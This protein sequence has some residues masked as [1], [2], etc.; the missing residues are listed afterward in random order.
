MTCCGRCKICRPEW[1]ELEADRDRLAARVAE[2]ERERD[3]LH[4]D[5]LAGP[6]QAQVDRFIAERDVALAE[7]ERAK[8]Q[9]EIDRRKI[10]E[11]RLAAE[12]SWDLV[13]D[14][15]GDVTDAT[16]RAAEAMAKAGG[17]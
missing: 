15:C 17:Q 5:L 3:G 11:W 7:L 13:G 14:P 2:L 1:E 16:Q 4:A 10:G 9:A 8:L 12:L 6:Q